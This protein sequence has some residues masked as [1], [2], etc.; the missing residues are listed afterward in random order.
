MPTQSQQSPVLG[1]EWVELWEFFEEQKRLLGPLQDKLHY[2]FKQPELLYEA[3]T[4]RSAISY[5]NALRRRKNLEALSLPWNERLEF[6]GD[7]VLGLSMSSL[8]WFRVGSMASEGELSKIRAQLVNEQS[9]SKIA[10]EIGLP[11][12]LIT[13]KGER[14]ESLR[15]SLLGDGLEAL[16][17]AVY[18]DSDFETSKALVHRLFQEILSRDL[19]GLSKDFKSDLQEHFQNKF[20]EAPE[21]ITLETQGPAHNRH[22]RV[23]VYFHGKCLGVGEGPS[24]KIASQEAARAA[25]E[26]LERD[27]K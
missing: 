20:R 11:Q 13:G 2:T 6:L 17:G 19:A 21:Y 16:I 3:L 9:L 27:K 15:P 14:R 22:F 26:S 1:N 12:A 18:L 5:A 10:Q 7:S 4:H 8:L 25:Y 24:K 23:G